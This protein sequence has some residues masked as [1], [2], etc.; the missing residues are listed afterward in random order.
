MPVTTENDIPG[1]N[2]RRKGVVLL[3]TV[4]HELTICVVPLLVDLEGLF[5]AFF[6]AVGRAS[7]VCKRLEL[8]NFPEHQDLDWDGLL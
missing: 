6:E 2:V 1:L 5:N 8:S 7:S 3:H 4:T